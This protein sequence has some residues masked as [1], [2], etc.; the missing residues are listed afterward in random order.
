MLQRLDRA[1]RSLGDLGDVVEGEVGDEA[2]RDHLALVVGQE[3][4][5]SDEIGIERF[6]GR[7]S[8]DVRQLAVER[9]G[10]SRP[11]PAVVDEAV[12]GNREDPTPQVVAIAAEP[13]EVAGHLEEHL[14]E[15]VLGVRDPLAAEVAQHGRGQLPVGI[16]R[17][18]PVIIDRRPGLLEVAAGI[19]PAY[20]ALQ[21]LA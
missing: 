19:E 2:E 5:G 14:A 1:G 4:E 11:A 17:V 12:A 3:G 18:H 21:A 7:M 15:Q 8:R 13:G 16:P 6:G 20:R 9:L 10:P